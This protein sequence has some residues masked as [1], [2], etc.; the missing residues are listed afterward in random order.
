MTR[1]FFIKFISA[2][3]VIALISQPAFSAQTAVQQLNNLMSSIKS[4]DASFSQL[5]TD[6]RGGVMQEVKG[7]LTI[8]RPY[9]FR[10]VTGEPFLQDV[11]SNGSL[12]WV[13][14]LDLEQVT[15]QKLDRRVG[16][17]PALLLSGDPDQIAK[18][19]D[20]V[21]ESLP[22]SG[23]DKK[24]V[25]RFRLKPKSEDSLFE[26]LTVTFLGD[27]LYEM[28]LQDSLGQ[29]TTIEFKD[30]KKNIAID[31]SVFEFTPPKGVDIIEDF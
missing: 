10:W 14:D 21:S 24:K 18:S 6:P 30:V 23:V 28:H 29:R 31:P 1:L 15:V 8:Q 25:I 26:S 5:V 13:H 17:T 27:D 12:L 19:F 16:N 11:I 4:M 3:T 7:Q 22:T 20:V 9:Q 2:A